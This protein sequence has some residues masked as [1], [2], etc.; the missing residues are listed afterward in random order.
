MRDFVGSKN[1]TAS[2]KISNNRICINLATIELV[3]EII[4]KYEF[5]E[6]KEK[7]VSVIPLPAVT[8][9]K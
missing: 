5:L 6:I 9:Q 3:D 8:K 1:V 2:S 4:D 7:K